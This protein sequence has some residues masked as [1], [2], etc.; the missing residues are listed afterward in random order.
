VSARSRDPAVLTESLT[1]RFRGVDVLDGVSLSVP[2]GTTFGLLGPNG[3]G[4]TTFLRILAGV[5]KPTSGLVSVFGRPAGQ[6]SR[7]IGYMPQQLA[8]YPRVTVWENMRYFAG[9]N[10]AGS[11]GPID[12][13][14][15]AVGLLEHK[16]RLASELSQGTQRRLSLACALAHDPRLLLLDE[17]TAAVDPL[18]RV[19]FW[20]HFRRLNEQGVTIIVTTH[21]MDEAERCDQIAFLRE[22]K[23]L[24]QGTPEEVRVSQQ[25]ESVEEA[26][27]R[28]ARGA[29][30]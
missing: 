25:A 14:L 29:S 6:A 22:G 21:A 20:D 17:A 3:S 11:S 30:S 26:F 9:L 16:H 7:H 10:G 12:A 2:T 13:A 1:K 19:A 4:K 23:V 24:E 5:L 15:S 8:I 27:L 28:L 18:L